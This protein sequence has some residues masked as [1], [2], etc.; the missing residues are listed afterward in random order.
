MEKEV[1]EKASER[2][3][4]SKRASFGVNSGYDPTGVTKELSPEEDL[5]VGE[6]YWTPDRQKVFFFNCVALIGFPPF[7]F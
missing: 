2:P 6:A 4:I 3:K 7:S 5:I 1:A